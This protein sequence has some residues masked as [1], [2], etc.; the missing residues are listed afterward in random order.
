MRNNRAFTLIELLVVIAIIAILAAILFPVFS[1]AKLAAKKTADLSNFNQI[2]KAILL[3]ANDNDDHSM[4]TAHEHEGLRWYE[5]LYPYAKSRDVFRTPAYTR[6]DVEDEHEGEMVT[7]D[8]D[9][10]LNGLFSHGASLTGTSRPAEQIIVALRNQNHFEDDY[11][12]WPETAYDNAATADWDDLTKYVGA[13]EEGHE[14]DWF[15]ERLEQTPWN[16]N[17]SNFTFLDG[18]AKFHRWTETVKAPL[19][20]FHNVDRR[21]EKLD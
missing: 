12:P 20:G 19:P 5:A 11:H 14:H 18:H 7:P 15:L 16:K 9:Y 2:G 4:V 13:E 10:S 3:Y 8:S 6:K 1:Q 17:G 21:V